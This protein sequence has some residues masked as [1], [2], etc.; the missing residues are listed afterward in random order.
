MLRSGGRA[1]RCGTRFRCWTPGRD[2]RIPSIRF[3]NIFITPV[4][5]TASCAWP[6]PRTP[7][8]RDPARCRTRESVPPDSRGQANGR[9]LGL[10]GNSW[11]PVGRPSTPVRDRV[12]RDTNGA[13][14]V[15]FANYVTFMEG[16]S[17]AMFEA[18]PPCGVRNPSVTAGRRITGMPIPRYYPGRP[19]GLRVPSPERPYRPSLYHRAATGRPADLSI[20][21]HQDDRLTPPGFV[22]TAAASRAFAGWRSPSPC[23]SSPIDSSRRASLARAGS[24]R[25]PAKDFRFENSGS[26]R[27]SVR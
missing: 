5:E 17:A 15:Y 19:V 7:I 27:A 18:R 21:S 22:R 9:C 23:W 1:G 6:R 26:L 25:G 11:P 16:P 14:L 10:I 2:P 20:G 8:F 4:R 3:G 13:G 24:L 12:D